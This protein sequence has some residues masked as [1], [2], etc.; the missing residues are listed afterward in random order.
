MHLSSA[1]GAAPISF[2]L[3]ILKVGACSRAV[4]L[5][6]II[7]G[8]VAWASRVG[9]RVARDDGDALP[10][11]YGDNASTADQPTKEQIQIN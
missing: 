8:L 11:R 6:R 10:L 7:L 9:N 4:L 3:S 1:R 5:G 2:G